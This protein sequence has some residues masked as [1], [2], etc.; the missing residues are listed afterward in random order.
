MKRRSSAG[1]KPVKARRR[2]AV[3]SKRRKARKITR[4][5]ASFV[6]DKDKKIVLLTHERDEA[7][8][9][10]I[11]TA[12]VLEV[13]SRSAFD[14]S[15]VFDTV[16]ESSARLCR[17]DRANIFRF[18]GELLRLAATFNVPQPELV[19]LSDKSTVDE[20]REEHTRRIL[21]ELI[22]E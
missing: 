3:I 18:D 8:E 16:V 9:Q 1:S 20:K 5:P 19:C 15:A 2:K 10:Q 22:S 6:G 17:A 4:S 14:L 13:I 21:G 11:A 12:E 7:L